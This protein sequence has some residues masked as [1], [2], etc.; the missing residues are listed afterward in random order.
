M[1]TLVTLLIANIS[2]VAV[3]YLNATVQGRFHSLFIN[4]LKIL[5]DE[6]K[7]CG[8][9]SIWIKRHLQ[10]EISKQLLYMYQINLVRG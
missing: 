10:A 6:K 4:S 1:L 2:A 8:I 3:A 5:N 9:T 7:L